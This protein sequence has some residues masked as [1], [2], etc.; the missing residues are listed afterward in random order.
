[1][2]IGTLFKT[3]L[4]KRDETTLFLS[5]VFSWKPWVLF[6]SQNDKAH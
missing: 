6:M 1:M 4:I 5:L 3:T 2:K